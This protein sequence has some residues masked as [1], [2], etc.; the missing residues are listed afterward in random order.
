MFN[1]MMAAVRKVKSD[2]QGPISPEKS[3]KMQLDVIN[4]LTIKESGAFLS[5]YGNTTEWL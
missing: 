1:A 5:H 4:N 3:V 2:F